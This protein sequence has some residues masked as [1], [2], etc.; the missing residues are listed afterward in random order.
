MTWDEREQLINQFMGKYVHVVVDRPI[1]YVHGDIV[2]PV[3]YGYLPGVIAGDLEEQDVY[4]LG[5]TEPV[6]EFNGQVIGAIRRKN[7]C[8][9][10]LVVAPA[11]KQ[12]H[13]AEIAEA[14][15]FQEQYFQYT[16]VSLLQKSCGVIPFRENGSKREYLILLQTNNCWS[17][18]K[19][20]MEPGE[21]QEETA[22]RE[23]FEETGLWG[24]LLDGKSVQTEYE[25]PTYTRK[26]VVLFLGCVD[27]PVTCQQSEIVDY[28]WASGD[29]LEKYLHPDTYEVCKPLLQQVNL[30]KSLN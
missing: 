14:V 27:G 28:R 2:Y 4:I 24:T 19:G 16:V 10:K 22:L 23:L 8:E 1:G 29:E 9:D 15:H 25:I 18:P 20:H 13:Q 17:F 30:N 5:I 3:N 26:Q 6:S 7:D 21:T 12:Y 11:G